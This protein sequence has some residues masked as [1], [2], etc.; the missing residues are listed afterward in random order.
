MVI[1]DSAHSHDHVL[2]ELEVYSQLVT[3]NQYLVVEDTFEEFYPKNL[4]SILS[5]VEE[6]LLL[7]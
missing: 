2:S 5:A 6:Q 3:K 4:S 7:Q 1:L